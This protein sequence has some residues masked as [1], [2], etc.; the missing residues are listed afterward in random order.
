MKKLIITVFLIVSTYAKTIPVKVTAYTSHRSQTSKHPFTAAWGLKLKRHH[1]K[2]VIAVSRDLLKK[3]HL[4]AGSR[5]Y[6]KTKSFRG[7]VTVQDKMHKRW[8]NKV[9]LYFYTARNEA[10]RFGIK[11][12]T[13]TIN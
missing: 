11:K 10:L 2:K 7:Y 5:V 9:D 1:K 3:Y 4:K 8:R 6:L 12:G 13:I